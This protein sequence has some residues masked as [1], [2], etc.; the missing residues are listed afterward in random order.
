MHPHDLELLVDDR[1]YRVKY[2]HTC[3]IV[4]VDVGPVTLRL[5]PSALDLLATV[6]TRASAR[7]NGPV[8]GIDIN[9]LLQH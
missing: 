3:E 5:R 1:G 6:L 4:H 2:C 8:E 7:I 9:D